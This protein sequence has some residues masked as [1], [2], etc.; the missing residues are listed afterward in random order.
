[1]ASGE[2]PPTRLTL[3]GALCEGL[4]WEEFVAL[5]GRLILGWARRDFGLQ[6]CD[7]ENVCQEVLI[8]VWKGIAGYDAARGRFRAW[9]YTCTRN[10]VANLRRGRFRAEAI[11]KQFAGFEGRVE[12]RPAE[13]RALGPQDS[14][15]D[16]ALL[17]LEEEG[18][19][20][21]DLQAAV[22]QVRASVQPA[23]WKAFLLFEC[24]EMTAK[25]IGPR[26]GLSPAA[27]NQAVYRVR[28]LLPQALRSR[29]L[30]AK[31]RGRA[32]P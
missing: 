24:F 15:V 11:E 21:E 30:P 12:V 9:L 23:T 5:Y 20:A 6:D 22:R 14:P 26:L 18:F 19:V 29:D 13:V 3:I 1:M 28:Q 16:E 27:V 31:S 8:R 2:P 25:E 32:E 4:R 10:V 17:A 7:A